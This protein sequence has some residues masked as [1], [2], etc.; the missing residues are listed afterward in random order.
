VHCGGIA[1]TSRGTQTPSH[2]YLLMSTSG[3]PNVP[4][5]TPR[6]RSPGARWDS[7]RWRRKCSAS[8]CRGRRTRGCGRA[9]CGR[10]T[11]SSSRQR[12]DTARC[13]G[14]APAAPDDLQE[15]GPRRAVDA[16]RAAPHLCLSAVRQRDG[17][18]GD[19]PL[20]GHSSS[21]VTETVYCH[22]TRP[23]ITVGAET[24]DKSSPTSISL[25]CGSKRTPPCLTAMGMYGAAVT[26]IPPRE[27]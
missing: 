23:V 20:V 15:S 13:G 25:P 10:T 19:Q 9:F 18:R 7:P 3:A 2:Q 24:M 26:V 14:R 1:S 8:T 6:R 12:R 27:R 16:A 22:Q 21:N 5:Q 11:G 17:D 4:M